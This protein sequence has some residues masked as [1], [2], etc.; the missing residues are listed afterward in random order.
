MSSCPAPDMLIAAGEGVLPE[1]LERSVQF[2]LDGCRMCAMLRHELTASPLAEPTR[3]ELAR[4]GQRVE[5]GTR[6]ARRL[7][8]RYAAV[9]AGVA[10]A[11]MLPLAW[12]REKP[13]TLLRE[14]A[15]G[16]SVQCL[17]AIA[18]AR[19]RLPLATALVMRGASGADEQRYL[20]D[21]GHALA[22]YRADDF[23]EASARLESLAARY[24]RRVEPV[25]Y[26]G[27][28]RLIGGDVEAATGALESAKKI[29]S[30]ELDGD[31]ATYLSLARQAAGCSIARQ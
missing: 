14:K 15:T 4:L 18:K 1:S 13:V 12:E 7:G 29:G 11:L 19:L 16:L 17:P 6:R 20:R 27:V 22:P 31:I 3:E 8:V 21:L 30:D 9:A 5:A 2:H 24:P 25:F 23:R 28:A 26:L 10:I